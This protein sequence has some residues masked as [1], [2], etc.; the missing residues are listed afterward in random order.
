MRW[1]AFSL[2]AYAGCV[3]QPAP[4]P[5]SVPQW[6]QYTAHPSMQ[7]VLERPGKT[8]AIVAIVVA[9]LAALIGPIQMFIT[10]GLISSDM[11]PTMLG[12]V[13]GVAAIVGG[14]LSLAALAFGIASVVRRER[15]RVLAGAA[16]GIGAVGLVGLVSAGI[17][18]L[19]F[20][21]L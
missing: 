6:R 14:V 19:A 8:L 21:S 5:Q 13:N 9:A 18:A 7:P 15:P 1:V 16:I 10:L 12:V 3:T 4:Q 11:V 2:P 20:A 17:Q